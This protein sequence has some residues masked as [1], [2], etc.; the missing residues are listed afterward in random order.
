MYIIKL[1]HT[2]NII[3]DLLHKV[4]EKKKIKTQKTLLWP[5]NHEDDVKVR[6]HQ[7]CQLDKYNLQSFHK[8]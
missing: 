6:W 5:L 2:P 1:F 8:P 4:L 7:S 3:V